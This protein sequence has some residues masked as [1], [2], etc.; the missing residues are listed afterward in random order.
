MSAARHYMPRCARDDGKLQVHETF[1][2]GQNG[3]FGPEGQEI[4]GSQVFRFSKWIF[5]KTG[6]R[7]GW[8]NAARAVKERL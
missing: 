8:K 1:Q 5:A 7:D 2:N 3:P 6:W 4:S